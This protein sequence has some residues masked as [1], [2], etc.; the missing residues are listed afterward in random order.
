MCIGGRRITRMWVF[1]RLGFGS[2]EKKKM[3]VITYKKPLVFFFLF[4]FF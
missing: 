1:K 4:L 2:G 3:K